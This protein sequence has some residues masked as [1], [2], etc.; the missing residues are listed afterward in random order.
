MKLQ[1]ENPRGINV[2]RA[3][4]ADGIV[5]NETRY[6]RSLILSAQQVTDDW[7]VSTIAD[8]DE[9]AC[10]SIA[11]HEAEIVLLGTGAAHRQVDS[12]YMA[13]FA[14]RGMGLEVMD[15]SAACRTFNVL[16][17]EER[18]VVAA[19]I[20]EPVTDTVAEDP[21]TSV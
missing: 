10:Q 2:V 6:S 13:W 12:R 21:P 15:T 18:R 3:F 17:G 4:D 7:P 14:Q 16:V 5:V 19:L 20:V 1:L 11:R 8:F 9:S